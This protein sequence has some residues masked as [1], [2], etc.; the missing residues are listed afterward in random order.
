MFTVQQAKEIY[1]LSDWYYGGH[2]YYEV[3]QII[4]EVI[5]RGIYDMCTDMEMGESTEITNGRR[6]RE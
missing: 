4:E 2:D 5:N 6:Y 3:M 1:K